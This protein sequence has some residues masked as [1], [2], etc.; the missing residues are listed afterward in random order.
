MFSVI[1]LRAGNGTLS[2]L[3]FR[4]FFF[5]PPRIIFVVNLQFLWSGKT[6]LG[7]TAA[8]ETRCRATLGTEA[9]EPDKRVSRIDSRLLTAVGKSEWWEASRLRLRAQLVMC[10]WIVSIY[11]AGGCRDEFS[12]VW[13][14]LGGRHWSGWWGRR[15]HFLL[16]QRVPRTRHVSSSSCLQRAC[17]CWPPRGKAMIKTVLY[18]LFSI[19]K[20]PPCLGLEN[21]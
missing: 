18:P 11:N 14:V 12:G 5:P 4:V 9:T 6:C 17:F 7:D 10:P 8:I 20:P 2:Y 19:L 15:L 3:L 16:L 13:V 1:P 21:W